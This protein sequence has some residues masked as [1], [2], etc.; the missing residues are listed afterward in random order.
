MEIA[1]RATVIF[2]FVWGLTRVMGKRT[3]AQL[4][5]FE[6]VLLIM[7]GDL[8]QGGV[9][10]D[11]KSLT[12][13]AIAAST[14]AFWVLSFSFLSWRF[15]NADTII[16]GVPAVLVADGEVIEPALRAERLPRAELQAAA[17]QQGVASFDEVRLA[18]LET[19]G[20]I[21]FIKYD[22]SSGSST[23]RKLPRSGGGS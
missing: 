8:V 6:L 22:N 16:D 21:S 4:S 3:L 13:A 9:T 12:G 19:N 20:L 17:R 7:L 15:P 11:D 2:L 14:L 5:P 1:L 18:V 23:P 10:Q